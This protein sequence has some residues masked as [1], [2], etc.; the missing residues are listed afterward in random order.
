[1][2]GKRERSEEEEVDSAETQ[3]GL[4]EE[5][6]LCCA[7]GTAE[8]VKAAL[9][10]GASINAVDAEGSTGLVQACWRSSWIEAEGVVRL[11]LGKR[12]PPRCF[13]DVGWNALHFACYNSSSDIVKMVLEADS[14][15]VNLGVVD[16]AMSAGKTLG[17][18]SLMLSCCRSDD[19]AVKIVALLLDRGA[20]INKRSVAFTALHLACWKSRPEMVSLLLTRGASVDALTKDLETA[21]HCAAQN[22]AFGPDIIPLLCAAG[23]NVNALSKGNRTALSVASSRNALLALALLPHTANARHT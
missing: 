2:S 15:L 6:L 3:K 23:V 5:F 8:D 4:D 21:L 20:D 18:T 9:R 14:A 12:C 7:S 17:T 13:N 19:E 1:M 10:K 22:G 11:L 16:A